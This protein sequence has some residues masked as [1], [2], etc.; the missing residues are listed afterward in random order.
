MLEIVV[1]KP[2][3][4]L[5]SENFRFPVIILCL[6]YSSSS[7]DFSGNCDKALVVLC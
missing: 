2:S 3:D 6:H 7:L 1:S 4:E 5:S